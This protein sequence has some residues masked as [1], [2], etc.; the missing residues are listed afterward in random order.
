MKRNKSKKRSRKPIPAEREP[1]SLTPFL[2]PGARPWVRSAVAAWLRSLPVR[3]ALFIEPFAGPGAVALAVAELGLADRVLLVEGS[4]ELA[5]FWSALFGKAWPDLRRKILR[6]KPS[7]KSVVRELKRRPGGKAGLA[8]QALVRNRF[9][10]GGSL[11]PGVQP[12]RRGSFKLFWRPNALLSRIAKI[13]ALAPRLQFVAAD[14]F[15]AM[16]DHL[17]RQQVAF[18]VDAPLR[19][20][21]SAGGPRPYRHAVADLTRV[22]KIASCAWGDGLLLLPRSAEVSRLAAE[23]GLEEAGKDLVRARRGLRRETFLVKPGDEP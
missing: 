21:E 10:Q 22:F 16:E 19:P 15:K 14:G 12:L 8:F 13:Q 2:F 1:S 18:F 11:L 4:P 17:F 9:Q 20:G 7:R 3:P 23:H 5:A 6:F